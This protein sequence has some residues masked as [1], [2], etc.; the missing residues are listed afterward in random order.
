MPFTQ[1]ATEN[2]DHILFEGDGTLRDS[3]ELFQ[4]CA[5]S[6]KK[7]RFCGH[8]RLLYDNRTLRLEVSQHDVM[9]VGEQLAEVGVQLM[10]FRFAVVS[11]AET[12]DVAK[13]IETAFANR[14]AAYRRFDSR[15]EALRWLLA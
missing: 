7:A 8:T 10:G 5:M 4:W 14:S 12:A 9:T 13:F 15:E 11:S 1:T 3:E 2:G 6:I